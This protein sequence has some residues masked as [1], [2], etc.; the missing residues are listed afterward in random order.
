MIINWFCN[1]DDFNLNIKNCVLTLILE[2][3]ISKLHAFIL[4]NSGKIDAI[5][6][7]LKL[8]TAS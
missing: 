1:A 5:L 4:E 7:E 8:I 6:A 3:A 2:N